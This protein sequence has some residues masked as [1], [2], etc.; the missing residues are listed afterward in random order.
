MSSGKYDPVNPVAF[1]A[2]VRAPNA[3][4]GGADGD[5]LVLSAVVGANHDLVS[6]VM[7]LWVR[8]GDFV[9][10][11][12]WGQGAFWSGNPKQPDIRMDIAPTAAQL[13]DG[14]LARDCRATGLA[15]RS[16]DVVAFDPPYRASHGGS[17]GQGAYS[18][19]RLG[20]SLDSIN[21]VLDLYRLGIKEGA[22]LLRPGGRLLVKCQDLTYSSSLHLVHLDI[23]RYMVDAG[24]EL[25]DMFVLVNL[26]RLG[27]NT[28]AVN[29]GH[30]RRNHSYMLVGAKLSGRGSDE[31]QLLKLVRKVGLSTLLEMLDADAAL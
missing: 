10:D 13:A 18:G 31:A 9:V 22:R 29:Q 17:L 26:S 3:G 1:G 21:D 30:A 28:R 4:V 2:P 11:M 19:Y 24:L 8:P 14:V 20:G 7:R 12:T 25:A 6:E 23:L 27:H 5:P 16:A 15:S